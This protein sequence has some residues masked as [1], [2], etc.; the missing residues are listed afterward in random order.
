MAQHEWRCDKNP[1]AVT[2]TGNQISRQVA[3]GALNPHHE[4]AGLSFNNQLNAH[5]NG[6]GS[7][8]H[9]DDDAYC[10]NAG[11][12]EDSLDN[13]DIPGNDTDA[14]DSTFNTYDLSGY[15]NE[16]MEFDHDNMSLDDN[17]PS[18][19]VR[20]Q[21]RYDEM[22]HRLPNPQIPVPEPF[23]YND[24]ISA[25]ATCFAQILLVIEKHGGTKS[26]F[27]DIV[28][29]IY[30]WTAVHPDIFSAYAGRSQEWTRDKLLSHLAKAFCATDLK[31]EHLSA[32]LTDGRVATVSCFDF[33][34]QVR[35]IL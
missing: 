9:F 6:S 2:F 18:M 7:L 12:D 3:F 35:D 31:P 16:Y 4:V 28:K 33:A 17:L 22:K 5:T 19:F 24:D 30:A 14:S 20:N 25:A 8:N 26:M 23:Q 34:A 11:D 29:I 32:Q 10:I 15:D 1:N 13:N 21:L 27:D